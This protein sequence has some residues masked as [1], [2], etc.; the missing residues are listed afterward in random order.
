MGPHHQVPYSMGAHHQWQYRMGIKYDVYTMCTWCIWCVHGVYDV[1]LVYMMCIWY[2]FGVYMYHCSDLVKFQLFKTFCCNLYCC[3]L[4]SFY[5][6]TSYTKVKVAYKR[7]YRSL[8]NLD[9]RS[10]ITTHMVLSNVDSLMSW[11]VNPFLTLNNVCLN[12]VMGYYLLLL[13]AYILCQ[14]ILTTNG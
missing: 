10:S 13:I 11:F 8:L 5:N 7:I 6:Q 3:H 12:L 2:I 1:H 9:Y 4:W 14:V